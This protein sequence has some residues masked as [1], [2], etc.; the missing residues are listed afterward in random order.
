[1]S[2]YGQLSRSDGHSKWFLQKT[3]S[4]HD[5]SMDH[6]WMKMIY[7]QSFSI[8][9]YAAWLARNLAIFKVMEEKFEPTQEPVALVH[10]S[11]LLRAKSLEIDLARLLGSS[12]REEVDAMCT[13]S[14]ATSAYLASLD[15]DLKSSEGQFLLLAHHFLQYNAVLSGGSYLGSM[16]SQKLC[17]PHGA[18]GIQFYAFDGVV[19]GKESARVQKYLKDF[20]KIQISEGE[21]DKMLV[22]M[23]R[24]Y[25]ETEAL[26]AEVFEINPVEGIDYK[27]A[28]DSTANEGPPQPCSEQLELSLGELQAYTGEQGGRILLSISRE[29]LDVSMG[30]ELYGS[31]G[32]YSLLAGHDVSRCL[33][34]MSLDPEHLDDLRWTP[35]CA[36]DEETL[37]NWRQKLKEKYPVAGKL[38]GDS[39]TIGSEGLRKRT[40]AN[41][42]APPKPAQ[43]ASEAD[44]QKCPISGKE[45][46]CPMASIMGIGGAKAS[47]DSS[48]SSASTS[49]NGKAKGFMAGK[50]LV[51]SVEKKNSSE[52]SFLYR[53]CPLHWDDN[54]I[55]MVFVVAACS[56]LSGIFVGWNLR[57][58]LV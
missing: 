3:M 25:A 10:D 44:G 2:K 40:T 1:M 32:G 50:S 15:T 45:G 47:Q 21:R 7:K 16:V 34:T 36:E 54:T 22:A 51:A 41:A 9:Q 30:R 6:P 39:S 56:W 8:K 53:I 52:D 27:S 24:I 13:A 28:K 5:R 14:A 38:V 17:V 49:E 19:S 55:K 18:P 12:W 11:S 35:D 33:A 4:E 37:N 43:A 26:M 48:T 46:T 42:Q 58:M 31:G 20:D 23:K 57:K 29:L